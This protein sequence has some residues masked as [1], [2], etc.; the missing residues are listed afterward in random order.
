MKSH[1]SDS[2]SM[3]GCAAVVFLFN[4][5]PTARHT[6]QLG[7]YCVV[8]PTT[9]PQLFTPEKPEASWELPFS[10]GGQG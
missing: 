3:F 7:R 2:I 9:R 6:R 1:H 8:G 5:G 4:L 10:C